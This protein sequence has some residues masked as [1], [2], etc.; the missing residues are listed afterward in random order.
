MIATAHP[1]PVWPAD[2]VVWQ[3]TGIIMNRF[4]LGTEQALDVLR[5]MSQRCKR[6]MWRVAEEVIRHNDPVRAFQRLEEDGL[7][8]D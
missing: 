7:N 4:D 5:R 8:P 1:R 6:P 3:A 2:S